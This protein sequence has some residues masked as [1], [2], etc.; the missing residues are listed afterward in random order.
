MLAAAVTFLLARFLYGI[1]TTDVVTFVAIPMLLGVVALIACYLPAR[2]A[3][4][5]SPMEALG[6]E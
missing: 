2:R 5:R 4:R 1:G 6:V 3:S